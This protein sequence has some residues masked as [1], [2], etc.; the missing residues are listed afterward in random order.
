MSR[1]ALH[2]TVV[3][4]AS[5]VQFVST[6]L[7]SIMAARHLK[8]AGGAAQL[9]PDADI[10]IPI[11]SVSKAGSFD[12]YIH[13]GLVGGGPPDIPLMV[14]SGNSTLILPDYGAISQLPDFDKNYQV[15]PNDV[16][17]PWGAPAKLVTGPI[18]LP[19]EGGGTY[20]IARCRFYACTGLNNEGQ[21]TAN[22]G[23][24]RVKP[25][26]DPNGLQSPFSYDPDYTCV[27]IDYAPADQVLGAAA[28][29]HVA[30]GSSLTL[31]KAQP[32]GYPMMFDILQGKPWMSL[33][34]LSLS[35]GNSQTQWPGTR[36][37]GSIAMID[38]GGGPVF[39]SDPENYLG[40]TNWPGA[41]PEAIPDFWTTSCTGISDDLAF[42]L[43]D[44]TRSMS[45]SLP[46]KALPPIVQG[47]SL[48]T[49]QDCYFM[50]SADG[51]NIGG[52]TALFYA[53]L[54]DYKNA[55]VGFR[56]KSPDV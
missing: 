48:V 14:D 8:A 56:A 9:A 2:P 11:D 41:V 37:A 27:Q 55:K 54:I 43:G 3:Q 33:R 21:P 7:A 34:P 42:S 5:D 28:T 25:W 17:E 12:A 10:Q 29:P 15:A 39:L 38:T 40:K 35:I 30:P 23:I 16:T 24:G 51:M 22:F 19:R 6:S 18:V 26:T 50:F 53:I 45:F 32:G 46:S 47:L 13:V 36:E 31:S 44:G 4:D 20:T 49:C 1:S 52:L